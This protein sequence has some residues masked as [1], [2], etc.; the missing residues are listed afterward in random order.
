MNGETGRKES[1][2]ETADIETSSDG[3]AARFAGPT[4]AWMLA[5]Q[6]AWVRGKLT[7]TG[8]RRVLDVG[9]GHG[10][11][12]LPLAKRGF[13]VEV[14]GSAPEC[15][16]RLGGAGPNL[17]FTVG[18][19]IALPYSDEAF[20]ASVSVRLLPH[21]D[22]WRDLVH[23]LCRVARRAVLVDYPALTMHSRALAPL[24][25]MKKRLEGNT[26]TWRSFTHDEVAAA[27]AGE[28]FELADRTGQFAFPLV[29]HRVL[30]CVPLSRALE[31]LPAGIGW[32][33]RHGSP[34]LALFIRRHQGESSVAR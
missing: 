19:L 8:V 32:T 16:E 31:A 7:E 17:R 18:N 25:G 4:G 11:L 24:F 12:A 27:F 21:C 9:G 2:P 3:Y 26:R 13:E 34:A 28:G 20:D 22:R 10:Q 33:R 5:R 23:E 15:A 30:R 14:V 6:E 1:Y 29:L